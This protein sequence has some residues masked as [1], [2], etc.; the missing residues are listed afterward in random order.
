MT[1]VY[2]GT[3]AEKAGIKVADLIVKLDGEDIPC[4]QIG[5]EEVFPSLIRQYEIGAEVKLDIIRVSKPM[6]IAVSL[7]AAP[8]PAR[9]YPK[10]KRASISSSPPATLFFRT[11]LMGT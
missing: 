11:A 7:E 3:T 6:T 10:Y 9:D 2:P 4:D 5:D 1:Q 8:K